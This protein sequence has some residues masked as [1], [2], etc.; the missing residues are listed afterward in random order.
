VL[1][2]NGNKLVDPAELVGIP[3]GD[4]YG[5]D[6]NNPSNVANPIH[7]VGDYSTPMTHELQFGLDREIV[8]NFGISGTVTWRHIGNFNWRNNGVRGSDYDQIATLA[9]SASPVGSYSVPIYGIRPDRIPANRAATVYTDREDYY[10]RYVGFEFAATKRMSDRWM[11]R[12]GFSTNSHTE[13]FDSLQ[14]ITDPTPSPANP[15]ID[16]GQ[17]ITNDTASGKVG[18]WQVLPRY[19]FILT[20]VYQAPWQI[21]FGI[22]LLSRQGY[23]RPYNRTQ[24]ATADPI[25]AS[26]TVL[27]VENVTDFRLPTLTSLDARVGKE[28][29]FGRTR[30]N[31]DLDI[32]NLLNS[33]TVLLRQ[34]DL[35]VT[36][37]D[38]VQEIMNPRVLRVGVRF[39]F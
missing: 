34:Y 15:N 37:A 12:F 11:A 26:K 17:V 8:R 5:F 35:R 10:Q 2:A 27:L 19:Q 32:F 30:F 16:G 21:N 13:H 1:D 31:V 9:G 22:N 28:F 20:G 23:A 7:S 6:I 29:T 25:G 14:A 3:P 36:T 33:S 24:V 18:I 39:N 38:N 4:W